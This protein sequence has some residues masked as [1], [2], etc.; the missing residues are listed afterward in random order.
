MF[1]NLKILRISLFKPLTLRFS[2]KI[3][4]LHSSSKNISFKPVKIELNSNHLSNKEFNSII[5][6]LRELSRNNNKD[7]NLHIPLFNRVKILSPEYIFKQKIYIQITL[8]FNLGKIIKTG[9][10][11]PFSK[12]LILF[13]E[14]TIK[15]IFS[16][17]SQA[18][19]YSITF[20]EF[21]KLL[22]L[23]HHLEFINLDLINVFLELF[24]SRQSQISTLHIIP[25]TYNLCKIYALLEK[26]SFLKGNPT[27]INKMKEIRELIRNSEEIN[28]KIKQALILNPPTEWSITNLAWALSRINHENIELW[29]LIFGYIA[30]NYKSLSDDAFK[31]SLMAIS[32]QSKISNPYLLTEIKSHF[33]SRIEK[34]FD[35][36]QVDY[37][38]RCFRAFLQSNCSIINNEDYSLPLYEN[39]IVK[40]RADF[41]LNN[42]ITLIYC[43]AIMNYQNKKLINEIIGLILPHLTES[44]LKNNEKI[45]LF[46]WA[47]SVLLIDKPEFWKAFQKSLTLIDFNNM[48]P[49]NLMNEVLPLEVMKQYYSKYLLKSFYIDE[50]KSKIMKIAFEK[51][52]N[53]YYNRKAFKGFDIFPICMASGLEIES[54]VLLEFY[55]VDYYIKDFLKV[56]FDEKLKNLPEIVKKFNTYNI[57]DEKSFYERPAKLKQ[58]DEVNAF[59]KETK[60]DSLAI[61]IHG[62]THFILEERFEKGSGLIKLKI[63]K[64]KGYLLICLPYSKCLEI[65]NIPG[66]EDKI[67]MVLRILKRKKEEILAARSQN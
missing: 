50:L 14:D 16:R 10:D 15:M 43:F 33:D 27:Y 49:R 24:T 46:F 17:K 48:N 52:F 58:F 6:D 25:C 53:K 30:M 65:G 28:E 38:I 32:S 45:C 1:K 13:I 23:S 59:V 20:N 66:L 64:D 62:I 47:G 55:P 41:K 39:F 5:D 37:F 40:R 51:V 26:S 18:E 12:E 2:N 11:T 42:N 7:Q 67:S 21:S 34:S 35:T 22:Y 56:D 8:C 63:L 4:L 31:T 36:L 29:Q 54:E 9:E 44:Y 61:E 3:N 19:L 60:E 57:A